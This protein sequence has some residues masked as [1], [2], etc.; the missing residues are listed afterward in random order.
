MTLRWFRVRDVVNPRAPAST[1]ARA[2]WAIAAMSSGAAAA[3]AIAR[4][5]IT[6]T[7][8]AACGTWVATSTSC[9][10]ASIASR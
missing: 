8:S 5:P 3:P 6:C 7:R 9:G 10:R 4:F 2:S 1:P